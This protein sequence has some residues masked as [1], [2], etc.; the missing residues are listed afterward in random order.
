VASTVTAEGLD[1][2]GVKEAI[3]VPSV[4]ALAI[5]LCSFPAQSSSDIAVQSSSAVFRTRGSDYALVF[6]QDL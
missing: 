2:R 4:P 6:N 1:G 3:V 5:S